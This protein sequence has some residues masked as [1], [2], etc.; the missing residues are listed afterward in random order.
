MRKVAKAQT[1]RGAV[2][3]EAGRRALDAATTPPEIRDVAKMAELARRW[4]KEQREALDQQIAWGELRLDALRKLGQ[5]LEPLLTRHRP[6]KGY[7][8]FRLRDE[9]ISRDPSSLAQRV[10]RVSEAVY[11]QYF[12]DARRQKRVPTDDDFFKKVGVVK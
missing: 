10:F 1:R 11:K 7:K 6:R 12:A 4:A 9:G 3:I 5:V 2:G 8:G